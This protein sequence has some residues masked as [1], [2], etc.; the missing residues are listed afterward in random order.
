MGKKLDT[1]LKRET[2]YSNNLN[3][4][5]RQKFGEVHKRLKDKNLKEENDY[6]KLRL[7][8]QYINIKLI[9]KESL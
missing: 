9:L 8:S 5:I 7:I 6:N 3:E 1:I 4:N 2:L